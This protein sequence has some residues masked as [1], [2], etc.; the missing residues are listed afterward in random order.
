[1][2]RT[3]APEV[4][5]PAR[6]QLGVAHGVLDILVT[7]VSLQR[8]GSWPRVDGKGQASTLVD[9]AEQGIEALGRH[10]STALACSSSPCSGWTLGV[11][12]LTLRTCRRP[13]V[14]ST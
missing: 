6:R 9:A 8:A 13:A 3:S 11:P 5:E 4:L 1:M 10:G 2:P 14:S 7:E 12:F